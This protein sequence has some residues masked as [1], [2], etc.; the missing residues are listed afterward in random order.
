MR[1]YI[2]DAHCPTLTQDLLSAVRSYNASEDVV[3]RLGQL[4]T[5]A[6]HYNPTKVA[7][8]LEKNPEGEQSTPPEDPPEAPRRIGRGIVTLGE[9]RG[10][11]HQP[12]VRTLRSEK[13]P[14]YM[15]GLG[16]K[17]LVPGL[18]LFQWALC[19]CVF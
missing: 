1:R 15:T 5:N 11:R 16:L 9:R 13:E 14:D 10:P 17:A 19:Y 18:F 8:K 2:E 4:P 3:E 12:P 6:Q 7:E